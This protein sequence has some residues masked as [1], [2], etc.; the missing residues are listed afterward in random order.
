[1]KLRIGKERE[2]VNRYKHEFRILNNGLGN[3]G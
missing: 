1:M 2:V 3:K